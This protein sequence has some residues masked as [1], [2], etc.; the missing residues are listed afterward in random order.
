M[1]FHVLTLFPEM[2]MHGLET[3]IT[4]R[5]IEQKLISVDA[6]NIRDFSN[7]KHKKVDDYPYGGG[8][9]MLMQAQPV[10]DAYKSIEKKMPKDAKKRVIYVTPQ[11]HSFN[12]RM[13][14]D[15]A[16]SDEVVI[17][18]GHYEGI[19]E[20]VLEEIVTDYVSI[21]D[22]VLTGGELAAM[23]MIDAI[24][25]LVKGVLS[26]DDSARTESFQAN[27]LEHPQ[28]TR[29]EVWNGK[30]VPS[31]LLSGNQKNIDKWKMDAATE[32]TKNRRPDLYK[33]HLIM[34]E[35]KALMMNS[36]LHHIDMIEQINRC[37]CDLIGFEGKEVLLRGRE[38]DIYFHTCMD[39][40][41]KPRLLIDF[42]KE[43]PDE[44]MIFHQEGCLVYLKE[45]QNR[46]YRVKVKNCAYTNREKI[47]VSGLYRPDGKPMPNG[48]IIRPIGKEYKDT[49]MEWYHTVGDSD[50]IDERIEAGVMH[51]AFIEDELVGFIGCHD[52]GSIGMLEV[53]PNHRRQK[54][55]KALEVYMINRG[56]ELGWI[57]YGQVIEGNEASFALQ[58]NLGLH[59]SKESIWWI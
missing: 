14:E 21:G 43:N 13:A 24:S 2:V 10:Y 51:G 56:I 57:P 16:K 42:L 37:T 45:I 34:E 28:Y 15:F 17:L 40:T 19:D 59:T 38:G 39:E 1:N 41:Q 5:A 54:I 27:L 12:Q 33:K 35:I 7:N 53:S 44:V 25:R 11:G 55:G 48:L 47:S 23:V 9:G 36:K 3:S 4:G 32:R 6:V 18:C 50:Y 26:N 22:Y 20:R 31:V 52:D 29:P 8:A 46:S 30:S 49:I 58:D